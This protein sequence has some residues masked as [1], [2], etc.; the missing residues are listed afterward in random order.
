MSEEKVL[1]NENYSVAFMPGINAAVSTEVKKITR[2]N[3]SIDKEASDKEI[4]FW[5][6]DNDFPQKVIEDVRKD[7]EIG[8]LLKK[9]ADLLYSS[10]LIILLI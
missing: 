5:G 4:L 8:T 2:P 7:P 10:G 9:Q 6:E 3:F 1:I